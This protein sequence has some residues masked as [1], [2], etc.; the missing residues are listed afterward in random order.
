MSLESREKK[1]KKNNQIGDKIEGAHKQVFVC[2]IFEPWDDSNEDDDDDV[3]IDID[4]NHKWNSHTNELI[5]K[6]MSRHQ[7][8]IYVYW[9]TR[10]NYGNLNYTEKTTQN[11]IASLHTMS[12]CVGSYHDTQQNAAVYIWCLP[13]RWTRLMRLARTRT[14]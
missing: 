3:D 13:Y 12:K 2:Y 14:S 8:I 4:D 1:R 10:Q 7:Y 9:N 5:L 11:H 6:D